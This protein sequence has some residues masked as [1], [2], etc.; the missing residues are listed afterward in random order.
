MNPFEKLC[1]N[2]FSEDITDN[3]VKTLDSI[4]YFSQETDPSNISKYFKYTLLCSMDDFDNFEE[5]FENKYKNIHFLEKHPNK[6]LFHFELSI[7]IFD[8][9]LIKLVENLKRLYSAHH[10]KGRLTGRQQQSHSISNLNE[11]QK[12]I[13]DCFDLVKHKIS[14]EDDYSIFRHSFFGQTKICKRSEIFLFVGFHQYLLSAHQLKHQEIFNKFFDLSSIDWNFL[15]P[16][17]SKISFPKQ[18]TLIKTQI[19]SLDSKIFDSIDDSDAFI[20]IKV[21]S[22]TSELFVNF[23]EKNYKILPQT[24][25]V[26][27][28]RA[29]QHKHFENILTDKNI[30]IIK[31]YLSDIEPDKIN[32]LCVDQVLGQVKNNNLITLFIHLITKIDDQ[33]VF[34]Q[35]IKY[36]Q[37]N[38]NQYKLLSKYELTEDFVCKI[39]SNLKATG[40]VSK[41]LTN[42]F[43]LLEDKIT[44]SMI[45]NI[46][47][48][49][50]N[51]ISEIQP[52]IL[53]LKLN[54]ELHQEK[55]NL[56]KNIVKKI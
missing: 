55:Q 30:H 37:L 14:F 21:S 44:P 18:S 5:D 15:L 29:L 1:L 17:L 9:L 42:I 45:C 54:K 56:S 8:F 51:L 48:T 25:F 16:E 47:A 31:E 2:H 23:A 20:L 22:F 50:Q 33:F 28:N 35:L 26:F 43:N 53:K 40:Q 10:I 52:I 27:F 4:I 39:I 49:D 46:L 3:F 41:Y 36:P 24:K 34:L 11:Q 32:K 19:N 38:S 6:N 13:Y 7:N 12:H